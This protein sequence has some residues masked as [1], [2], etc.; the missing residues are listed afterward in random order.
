MNTAAKNSTWVMRVTCAILF[1]LFTFAYLYYYQGDTLAFVQHILSGGKTHYDITVGAILITLVLWL[2]QIGVFA[3]TGLTKRL[4]ALTYLPSVLLL[5]LLTDLPD[6]EAGRLSMGMWAWGLPLALLSF[7]ILAYFYAKFQPYEAEISSYGVFSRLTWINVA[8]LGGMFMFVGLMS[9]GNAPFHYQLK[10]ERYIAVGDY[11]K[12]LAVGRNASADSAL[13]M[14]QM[15]ALAATKGM[16]DHLFEYPLKGGSDAMLPTNVTPRLLMLPEK[17]I[18]RLVGVQTIQHMRPMEYIAWLRRH[19]LS[20]RSAGDYLLCG[21]LLD[22]RLDVFAQEVGHYYSMDNLPK[23]YKE[24]LTL[25][26]HLRTHPVAV[27][28]STVMDADFQDFQN[29][30]RTTP[31]KQLFSKLKDVYGNTYWCYYY[32]RT[33]H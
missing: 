23:H 1:L 19:H 27:Y 11:R 5:A 17:N 16:G 10:M 2:L 29:I 20:G 3:L 4:H 30:C 15:H 21:Y 8:I 33:H 31:K 6:L 9:L 26:S 28:H 13:T 14:L 25:Y 7:G 12:A 18:Y 22:G 32:T 24:A